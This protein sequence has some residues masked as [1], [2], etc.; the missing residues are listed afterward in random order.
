MFPLKAARAVRIFVDRA[1]GVNDTACTM[2]AVSFIPTAFT[3]HAVSMIPHA[4]VNDTACIF[5][6]FEY[7]REFQFIFK[8][9]LAP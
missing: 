3:A 7:L 6:K 9:A 4:H 8:K 2:N 5:K 1:C